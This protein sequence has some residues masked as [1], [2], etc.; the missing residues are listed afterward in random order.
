[1]CPLMGK[2]GFSNRYN[3]IMKKIINILVPYDFSDAARCALDYA[4]NY[5]GT[6]SDMHITLLYASMMKDTGHLEN[7][8][9]S[10]RKEY[11]KALRSPLTWMV[12]RDSLNNAIRKACEAVKADLIIMG[13]TGSSETTT[14][15]THTSKFILQA[16]C[17][18]LVI[19]QAERE[20]HLENIALVLGRDAIEERAVLETLLDVVRRFNAKVHVLTIENEPGDYGYSET[21]E[22][23]ENL[24][25]YYLEDFYADHMFIENPDV[26][27]GICTYAEEKEIDMIAILPRNHARRSSPSEG[28][29]TRILTQ[30]A[31][32]PVLA[33]D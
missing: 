27:Q 1:M 18:V 15:P 29:L 23:N 5:V 32:T 14:S 12:A 30:R 3:K 19:P 26:V 16:E 31:K 13:T 6:S 11:G 28:R 17:P 9:K 8:F 22:K 2:F 4:V 25:E 20:F 21:E 7:A 10:L 33:I 24:L